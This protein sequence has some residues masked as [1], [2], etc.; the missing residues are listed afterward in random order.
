MGSWKDGDIAELAETHRAKM[1]EIR[2]RLDARTDELMQ[3]RQQAA[4]AQIALQ[5]EKAKVA[6]LERQLEAALKSK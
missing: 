6:D 3:L 1:E 4:E 5:Q 2:T